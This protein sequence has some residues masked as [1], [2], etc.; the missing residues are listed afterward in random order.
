M[1]LGVLGGGVNRIMELC[2]GGNRGWLK[3]KSPPFPVWMCHKALHCVVAG[4]GQSRTWLQPCDTATPRMAS[5]A[6][7]GTCVRG[8]KVPKSR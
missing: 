2:I 3:T 8:K 6:G 5:T 4:V 1:A 7:K